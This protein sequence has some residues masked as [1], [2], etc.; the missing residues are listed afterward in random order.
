MPGC[1]TS[2]TPMPSHSGSSTA[3]RDTAMV[4]HVPDPPHQV[5]HAS[6]L[7]FNV[8]NSGD[9]APIPVSGC[10]TSVTPVPSPS[11]TSTASV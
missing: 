1:A 9:E 5:S 4:Q 8:S 3:S 6:Y 2:A 11:G 7:S 10:A